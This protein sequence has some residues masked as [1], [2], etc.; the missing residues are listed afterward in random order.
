VQEMVDKLYEMDFFAEIEK[1]KAVDDE[2]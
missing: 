1:E 2:A